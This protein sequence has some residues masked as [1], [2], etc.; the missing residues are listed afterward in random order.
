MRRTA[1]RAQVS[2]QNGRCKS[3]FQNRPMA[4]RNDFAKSMADV[5]LNSTND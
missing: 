5:S 4:V 1:T 2:L 3:P